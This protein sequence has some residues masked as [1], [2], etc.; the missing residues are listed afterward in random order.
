MSLPSAVSQWERSL[1]KAR[2]DPPLA[3]ER[4][5]IQGTPGHAEP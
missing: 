4:G 5:L 2:A 3:V 1:P